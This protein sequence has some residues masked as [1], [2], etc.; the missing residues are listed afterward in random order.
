MRQTLL[1][2]A[3]LVFL[4]ATALAVSRPE[5][6]VFLPLVDLSG[7]PGAAA[8][9]APPIA[10]GLSARGYRVVEGEG[11]ERFLEA[12]R[13]RYLDSLPTSTL[14]AL[15]A[16]CDATLALSVAIFRFREGLNPSVA[17]LLRL[18][19]SDGS[20]AWERF[21][22]LSADETQGVFGLGRLESPAAVVDEL[23]ERLVASLPK[24][25]A[26]AQFH[27]QQ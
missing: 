19:R 24:P 25:G 1:A 26:D 11:V 7:V 8:L 14:E 3:D 12:R 27:R 6:V 15:L 16:Q 22:A 20:S 5:T 17:V 23:V 4:A 18:V 21:G 13:V 9:V 2:L 10:A